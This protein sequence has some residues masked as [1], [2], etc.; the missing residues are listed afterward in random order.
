[1]EKISVV[2]STNTYQNQNYDSKD[3]SLLNGFDINREF[4]AEQDTVELHIYNANN[5]LLRSLYNFP[6]YTVQ[7]TVDNSSLY[8]TVYLNPEN[9]LKSLGYNLGQYTP[10]YNFYRTLFLSNTDTRFFIK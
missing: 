2:N 5:Q 9:D 8:D 10:V 4:G 6:N 3:S 1:M 7:N